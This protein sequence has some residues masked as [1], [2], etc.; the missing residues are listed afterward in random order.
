MP[1]NLFDLPPVGFYTLLEWFCAVL[2][3]VSVIGNL[4]LRRWAWLVQSASGAGYGV[5]F[6][7]QT[8]FGLAAVQIYFVAIALWAWRQWAKTPEQNA[9]KIKSLN[10]A[11]SVATLALWLFTSLFIG[12]LLLKVGEQHTAYIDAFTTVGSVLAQWFMARYI[13]QTWH[14]WFIVNLV[15]VALFYGSGL[16][17]TSILYCLFTILALVGARTWR[18]K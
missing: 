6:F 5:V 9:L 12:W 17:A 7:H 4:K 15:S 8:L 10:T 3:L 13:R 1:L 11:Q 2:G 16:I 14:L 18:V